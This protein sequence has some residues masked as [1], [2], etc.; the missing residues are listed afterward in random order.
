MKLV[1]L[2]LL[3]LLKIIMV[4]MMGSCLL[5][6]VGQPLTNIVDNGSQQISNG[7]VE[8]EVTDCSKRDVASEYG[9]LWIR[10]HPRTRG[11]P[12]GPPCLPRVMEVDPGR[13]V[14]PWPL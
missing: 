3:L 12:A 14:P 7:K 13:L 5:K 9:F 2:L 8:S 6:R 4:L 10:A 1:N 11:P